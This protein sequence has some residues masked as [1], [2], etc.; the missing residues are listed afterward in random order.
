MEGLEAKLDIIKN[1]I[2]ES[3]N[4]ENKLEES[5]QPKEIEPTTDEFEKAQT[6][7]KSEEIATD[8][9][10][11]TKSVS[12]EQYSLDKININL[13]DIVI[14]DSVS[15]L[16]ISAVSKDIFTKAS[17]TQV[18]A[19]QSAYTAE[20]TELKSSEVD[21]LANSSIFEYEAELKRLKVIF[22]HIANTSIGKFDYTTWTKI[23]SYD[24]LESFIFGIYCE[25]FP[26]VNNYKVKCG[27]PECQQ[28]YEIKVSNKDLINISGDLEE[29]KNR[30]NILK[31]IKNPQELLQ[32][33]L[34]PLKVRTI[35]NESKVIFDYRLPSI[36][37]YLEKIVKNI[38]PY[39]SDENYA[40]ILI[41]TY[42][43]RI[44][45]PNIK[46]FKESG[47]LK[48]IQVDVTPANI[49][50]IMKILKDL[51]VK[52]KID[53]I[54]AI[55]NFVKKYKIQYAIK[56]AVCPSCGKHEEKI[57]I[58]MTDLVFTALEQLMKQ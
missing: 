31:N 25:T 23:T 43:E 12:K 15:D 11:F 30:F 24:D 44:F 5:I 10:E 16:L 32:K 54:S 39:A 28:N 42:L 4:P 37:A 34:V 53:L 48:Y 40:E 8:S 27:N 41:L 38:K 33:S 57:E 17:T 56:D 29:F 49:G 6:V 14:Q 2:R 22:N 35:C 46:E 3:E 58:R 50:R 18:F 45:L 47:T 55:E 7:L 13:N 52:D 51:S 19:A 36:D 20:M 21:I 9:L 1:Q 26:Y